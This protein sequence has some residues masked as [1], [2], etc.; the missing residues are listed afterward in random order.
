M[1]KLSIAQLAPCEERVP[2]VKYGGTELVVSNLTEELVKRGHKVT[3]IASGDSKTKAKLYPVFSQSLRN[4]KKI[5]ADL[6]I[7]D[8]YK[9]IGL[10]NAI[11]FLKNHHFDLIHNHLGWRLLPW[12]KLFSAPIVTTLHGPLDAKYQQIIYSK[13]RDSY[14]VS[15]SNNQRQPLKYLNF[16]ATVYNG[17]AINKFNFKAQAGKYLAFLGRMSPEKGPVQAIKTAKQAGEKLIMAAKIDLVDQEYYQKKVK[18]LIDGRQIQFIGEINH[19]SKVKLLKNAKALLALIQWPEPFGLF[20]VEALACG[21]PVIA[22]TRGAAPEIIQSGKNGFL[23]E[24]INEAVAAIRQLDKINR[25][26]CRESAVKK[27]SVKKMVDGYEEVYAKILSCR[28]FQN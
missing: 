9:L 7:R 28:N 22:N 14:F 16:V 10:A 12:Q 4:D 13:Y 6:K 23:V 3:L 27:F 15:I 19:Q 25:H 1:P 2:P 17:I 21:A 5:G 8:A 26:F 11:I 20:M 18:P 24:N